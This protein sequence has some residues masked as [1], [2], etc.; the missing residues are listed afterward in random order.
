MLKVRFK[1]RDYVLVGDLTSGGAIATRDQYR[2]GLCSYAHLNANGAIE[3]LRKH[4][5]TRDD[6][7]VI[8]EVNILPADDAVDNLLS[9]VRCWMAG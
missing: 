3:R 9:D 5:G 1:R 6:L 4:I 2:H 7:T 8:R